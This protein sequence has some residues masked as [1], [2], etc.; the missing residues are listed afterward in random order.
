MISILLFTVAFSWMD[1]E[2]HEDQELRKYFTTSSQLTEELSSANELY[3]SGDIQGAKQKYLLI[4]LRTYDANWDFYQRKILS[5][6]L[7]K[8]CQIDRDKCED[9]IS[10]LVNL[11]PDQ[12]KQIDPEVFEP[13]LL[14]QV[15]LQQN[16]MLSNFYLWQPTDVFDNVKYIIVNG[17][18]YSNANGLTISLPLTKQRILLVYSNNQSELFTGEVSQFLKW[19]PK[20]IKT[21]VQKDINTS[22]PLTATSTNDTKA[23][24]KWWQEN[25]KTVLIW[26]IAGGILSY[27]VHKNNK[28]SSDGGS[29]V[30]TSTS[31]E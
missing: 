15:L 16:R 22:V 2:F 10:E 29:T 9:Y 14:Q 25:K 11:D 26:T 13:P 5:Y 28:S 24:S 19:T 3:Y 21:I 17:R 31:K 4:S 20:G 8:L 23:P 7:L 12:V 18:I 30:S 1:I 6:S 27:L